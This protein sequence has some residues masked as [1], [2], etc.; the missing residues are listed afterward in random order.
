MMKKTFLILL[1]AVLA[2]GAV[3]CA[4][5]VPGGDSTSGNTAGDTAGNTAGETADD[6]TGDTSGDT[7]SET[8]DTPSDGENDPLALCITEAMTLTGTAA[9]IRARY[10][11]YAE[12]GFTAVR[13]DGGF[14]MK[15]AEKCTLTDYFVTQLREAERVGLT[16]KLIIPTVM[17][18]PTYVKDDPGMYFY[19][20]QG[21][22]GVNSVSYFWDGLLSYTENALR[23]ELKA[24]KRSGYM[25]VVGGLVVDFGAAGEPIYPA[26]WTQ[27]R[28]ENDCLW[29]FGEAAERSFRDAMEKKYGDYA[30]LSSARGKKISS[31]DA[32]RPPKRGEGK[33]QWFADAIEWYYQVKRD[34]IEAQIGVY[35]KVTAEYG[36][37]VPL[38]LYMP[39]TEATEADKKQAAETADPGSGVCLAADNGFMV[40]MAVKYG[41]VLQY[42]GANDI[43][44]LSGIVGYM[45][46]KGC[47]DIPVYAENAGDPG[48]AKMFLGSEEELF[49]LG[50]AGLDFTN[51]SHIYVGDE[52][53]AFRSEL[54][55]SMKK[56]TEYVGSRNSLR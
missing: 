8:S 29:W 55:K 1:A 33:G 7:T 24:L 10:K 54:E 52:K 20:E 11:D 38:V 17:T 2:F 53:D 48:S 34:F 40:D 42:T 30:A 21:R 35:K 49:S 26:Q 44:R 50:L 4:G 22:Q 18:V 51:A 28:S 15:T 16:V 39:G 6:T 25:S 31:F 14:S 12:M 47:A 5:N 45:E 36:L 41:C 3:S 9:D 19:D 43:A 23:Q 27:G 13:I 32:V 56:W 37:S 46:K